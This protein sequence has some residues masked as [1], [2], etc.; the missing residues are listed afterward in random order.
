MLF[1]SYNHTFIDCWNADAKPEYKQHDGFQN[2]LLKEMLQD[3]VGYAAITNWCRTTDVWSLPEYRAIEDEDERRYAM[4]MA[5]LL[6]H[7]LILHRKDFENADDFIDMIIHFE[8]T[9]MPLLMRE[10]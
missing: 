2:L 10:K 1:E 9:Y 6:D 4:T 3:S 5:V 8:N 7:E